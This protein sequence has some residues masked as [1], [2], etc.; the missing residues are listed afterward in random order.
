MG[1]CRAESL[2]ALLQQDGPSKELCAQLGAQGLACLSACSNRFPVT[3]RAAVCRD[4]FN[5]L[6]SELNTARSSG[7]QQHKQAVR[8]LAAL[9]LREAP[10]KAEYLFQRLLTLPAVPL[11]VAKQLVSGGLRISYAQ[12]LAAA[13]SMV[14]GV[15]GWVQA[16]QQLGI[17]TDIPSAAVAICCGEDWVSSAHYS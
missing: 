1:H 3:V 8:W 13:N 15:E 14:A 5:I 16:Q 9:L 4:G 7:Q 6:D 12:L 10:E 2:A 11:D 17:Y